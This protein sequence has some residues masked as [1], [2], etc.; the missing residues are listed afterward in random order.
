LAGFRTLAVLIRKSAEF[1]FRQP[2]GHC[3]LS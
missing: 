3:A 1:H 2:T